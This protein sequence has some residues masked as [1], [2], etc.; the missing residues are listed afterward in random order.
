M[1]LFFR[2]HVQVFENKVLF[3]GMNDDNDNK[4]ATLGNFPV[5]KTK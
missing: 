1:L 3:D 5:A 4:L 2:Y